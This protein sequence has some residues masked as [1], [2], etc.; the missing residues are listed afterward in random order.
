LRAGWIVKTGCD[1]ASH[2]QSRVLDYNTSVSETVNAIRVLVVTDDPLA[3][4]GLATLLANQST[5]FMAGQVAVDNELPGAEQVY[6]PDV[7]VW[8]LGSNSSRALERATF[9]DLNVP[10]VALLSDETDAAD[11]WTAG[12]R[13]LLPRDTSAENLA[14]ALAAVAR[15]LTVIDSEF[16]AALLPTMH[17]QSLAQP[18]EALTPRELEVLRLMAEGQSN[19]AIARQLGISEHTVKFHVNAILGKLN[20]QSRTEAVVRATRLGL[21]LL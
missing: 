21:I 20:V 19:K 16:A 4:A 15:G 2:C 14:A 8:D 9:H 3:R 5:L 11:A 17:G 6:R 7:I 18:V 12:A 1:R 13:G 10:V